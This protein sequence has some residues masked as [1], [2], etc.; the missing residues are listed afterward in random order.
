MNRIIKGK[1]VRTTP[2]IYRHSYLA[3][4]AAILLLLTSGCAGTFSNVRP[5]T[6]GTPPA[7]HPKYLQIGKIEITDA[8]IAP[9]EA[10]DY[11][12]HFHQGFLA[13]NTEHEVF[14]NVLDEKATNI[15]SDAVVLMGSILDVEK[16]SEAM[17]LWVGM[18]AGQERLEGN[19]EIKDA[20]GKT[21]VSFAV[22]KSYLGGTG[23][24]G[25]DMMSFDDLFNKMGAY[26]AETTEEWLQGKKL[27]K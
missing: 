17:R 1:A 8:R 3:M 4:L 11:I 2:T 24:G 9:N 25:S 20:A 12:Y 21:L 19:F 18:G 5:I 15:S 16:G 13:W 14:A 22:H 10:R 23:S 26:V 7:I 27:Q 6:A